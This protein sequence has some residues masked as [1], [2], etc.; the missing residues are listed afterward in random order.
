MLKTSHAFD[1]KYSNLTAYNNEFYI[2]YLSKQ[3]KNIT[4]H[5]EYLS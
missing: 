5:P 2:F 4:S 3:E 1:G